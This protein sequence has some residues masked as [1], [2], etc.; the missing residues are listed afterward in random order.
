MK[1]KR[2][3]A[4]MTEARTHMLASM[5][6]AGS[7]T[8]LALVDG[9]YSLVRSRVFDVGAWHIIFDMLMVGPEICDMFS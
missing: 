3:L 4:I 2:E 5:H 8:F 1:E 7:I 9:Y 6:K